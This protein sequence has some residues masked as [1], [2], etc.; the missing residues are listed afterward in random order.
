VDSLMS[1]LQ[2]ILI[3][4]D[5]SPEASTRAALEERGFAVTAATGFET[6]YDQLLASPFDLVIV[7]T[8]QAEVGRDFVKRL[9]TTP[10]LNRTFVLTLA[11]WGTGQAATSL[12]EGADAFEP[13]P[14]DAPRLVQA[15]ERLLRQRAA[16]TATATNADGLEAGE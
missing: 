16:K 3:V 13:K 2:Q 1:R 15:V 11:E 5:Q 14:I 4:S 6:A 7:D 12:T 8:V 10:K 9:R